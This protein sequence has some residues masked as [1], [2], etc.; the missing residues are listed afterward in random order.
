MLLFFLL[1]CDL[2]FKTRR[3]RVSERY[4][5]QIRKRR[6][7]HH[8]KS[9]ERKRDEGEKNDERNAFKTHEESRERITTI[10]REDEG[11]TSLE[12][13]FCLAFFHEA[14]QPKLHSLEPK[15][16]FS[17]SLSSWFSS[18]AEFQCM[19]SFLRH[20]QPALQSHFHC[21]PSLSWFS[22]VTHSLP[23]SPSCV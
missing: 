20:H 14:L 8:L 19:I 4:I 21:F 7:R 22:S 13:T 16:S 15:T 6:R 12:R 2:L 23:S 11:K 1:S 3:D 17:S 9:E 5:L 18:S 10:E